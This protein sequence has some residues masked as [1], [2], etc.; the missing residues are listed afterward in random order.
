MTASDT[1]N[2]QHR[3]EGNGET[4]RRGRRVWR[5]CWQN[6][7]VS[8]MKRIGKYAYV[9]SGIELREDNALISAWKY[10]AGSWL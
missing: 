10:E 6:I 9:L 4:G 5:R 2:T 3:D 7:T 8:L 1:T